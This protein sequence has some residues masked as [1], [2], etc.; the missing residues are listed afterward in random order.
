MEISDNVDQAS[1]GIM[2]VTENVAQSSAVSQ[3]VATDITAVDGDIQGIL[4]SSGDLSD[5][6]G[7]LSQLASA[8]SERVAKFKT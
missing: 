2:E 1:A 4:A 3:D 8:L 6:A 5:K 7:A